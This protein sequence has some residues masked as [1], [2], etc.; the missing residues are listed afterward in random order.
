MGSSAG[1]IM[2]AQYGTVISNPEYASLLDIEPAI[3]VN[4]VLAVVVDD[5]PID[6]QNMGLLCKM[7]VGNYVKGS[8]YLN[9]DEL[10]KYECIP[11]MTKNYPAAFLLGSEYRNDMNSMADKLKTVGA[12]YILVDPF[13]ESG[14]EQPHCFVAAERVDSV[15]AEAFEKLTGFLKEKISEGT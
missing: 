3:N 8:I 15:A 7:L 6:Y 14:I 10:K 9:K 11:Y 13:A 5:A 4:Q 12:Y 2:T 1:A